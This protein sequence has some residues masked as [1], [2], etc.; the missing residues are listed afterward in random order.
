M[1]YKDYNIKS[2]TFAETIPVLDI[3]DNEICL[4]KNGDLAVLIKLELPEIYTASKE[5]YDTIHKS[6]TNAIRSLP[7]H[8]CLHKQDIYFKKNISESPE[9]DSFKDDTFLSKANK[10]HF[11]N[12][13]YID[14]ASYLYITQSSK[15]TRGSY[16]FGFKELNLDINLGLSTKDVFSFKKGVHTYIQP[17]RQSILTF[18]GILEGSNSIKAQILQEKEIL[19]AR[20]QGIYKNWLSL[21]FNHSPIYE[22]F[23][24]HGDKVWIGERRCNIF[25]IN[26]LTDLPDVI[27]TTN[28]NVNTSLPASMCTNLGSLLDCDHITNLYINIED[29]EHTIKE[30]KKQ[31][32]KYTSFLPFSIYNELGKRDTEEFIEEVQENGRVPVTSHANV[33]LFTKSEDEFIRNKALLQK[34]VLESGFESIEQSKY[35][36]MLYWSAMPGNGASLPKGEM[37][38]LFLDQATCMLINDTSYKHS[39]GPFAMPLIDR[40]EGKLVKVDLSDE[41]YL[42]GAIN[43]RNKFI[44]GPP[45]SGKSFFMNHMLRHYYE[46]GAHTV[47]VDIGD[48]YLTQCK[49]VQENTNGKDGLY[50]TYEDEKSM[51]FNPFIP[52]NPYYSEEKKE[53]L[54]ELIIALCKSEGEQA[55]D[56]EDTM[57]D[58]LITSYGKFLD[59]NKTIQPSLASF[60]EYADTQFEGKLPFRM[61]ILIDCEDEKEM[62]TNPFIPDNPLYSLH[63]KETLK[64]LIIALWKKDG[65]TTSKFEDTILGLLI[66]SY[67]FYLGKNKSIK[68][69]FN[70]FYEYADT[71]FR[72]KLA[73]MDT[74]RTVF[75]ISNFLTILSNYY[76]GGTY[77][78]LLNCDKELDIAN[79]RFVVFELRSIQDNQ[80]ILPIVLLMIMDLFT[81]KLFK[82]GIERKVM[83]IEE[84]WKAIARSDMAEYIKSLYKTARKSEGEAIVVSQE[85]DDIINSEI[86]KK[87]IVN[88]SDCKILMDLSGYKN[89]FDEV[90]AFLGLTDFQKQQVLSINQNKIKGLDPYKETWIGLG[91]AKS[92][93]Y[94]IDVSKEE[95]YGYNSRKDI[96]AQIE[97]L[98][99]KHGN[100]TEKAIKE[101]CS[102]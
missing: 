36:T 101:L 64:A 89:R 17:F 91:A 67:G 49:L 48:S 22:R 26:K 30:F 60:C 3:I 40:V 19:N 83:V 99:T 1:D 5:D 42:A 68:P 58:V 85:L 44:I 55:S 69:S 84:A 97:A 20:G 38:Y 100:N 98:A 32:K 102:N 63:K 53:A 14:H 47:I 35:N 24:S 43:N 90:Q 52:D 96:K 8:T 66:N 25:A 82:L 12:R 9:L 88:S 62:K 28:T 31:I 37:Y 10:K 78:G 34:A 80:E 54:K 13:K 65:E 41:L 29:K 51:Q 56:I 95:F 23:V 77:D 50:F 27:K 94:G 45:G 18:L 57:L 72:K 81:T 76:K 59:C 93:V 70:N 7:A 16:N 21:N 6:W 79:Q 33:M 71:K 11:A 87:T 61:S 73:S 39:N 75:D 74:G 15:A 92:A 2:L 86:V 4:L 46:G